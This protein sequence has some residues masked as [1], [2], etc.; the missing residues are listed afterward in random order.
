ML[1]TLIAQEE[2]SELKSLTLILFRAS[3]GWNLR[4]PQV[5]ALGLPPG[6]LGCPHGPRPALPLLGGKWLPADPAASQGWV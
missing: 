4:S 2:C 3:A 5:F 6:L 1:S